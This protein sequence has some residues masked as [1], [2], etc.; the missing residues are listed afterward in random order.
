M[1]KK[2]TPEEIINRFQKLRTVYDLAMLLRIN[3]EDIWIA[4]EKPLY[5]NF[6]IPKKKGG[7][8][9]IEAPQIKLK[10]IQKQ[11]NFYLQTLYTS[12]NQ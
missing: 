7:F 9:Q 4:A 5:R 6:F 10:N 8:R 11:L 2:L 12:L 3:Y 1:K